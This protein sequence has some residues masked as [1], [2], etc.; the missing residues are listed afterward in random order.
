MKTL[1]A[2]IMCVI[3]CLPA[4]VMAQPD[5]VIEMSR[6]VKPEVTI[7]VQAFSPA[8]NTQDP[9]GIGEEGRSILENDL[10]I[11]RFFAVAPRASFR[12]LEAGEKSPS[13]V[14]YAE[15]LRLG[16]QWLIKAEYEI[17]PQNKAFTVVFRLYDAVNERFLYGKQYSGTMGLL[18]KVMHRFAD[19]VVAQLTGKRGVA[20]TRL[21][22]VSKESGKKEIY[23]VDFD[24]YNVERL[25][26]DNS[27]ALSPAWSPNGKNIVFTSYADR[28]PDLVIVDASGKNRKPVLRLYGLNAAPSWSPDGSRIALVLSKDQNSEIYTI[29]KKI[30]LTRL[31][32]HFNIDTSPSWSPDGKLIVFASDRSGTGAPQIFIMDAQAGDDGKVERISFESSY[33]D[34][35][36]WSPDGDKIA[37]SARVGKGFRIKIYDLNTKKTEDFTVDSGSQEGPAWSPDGRYIA[38]SQTENGNPQIYIKKIGGDKARQLTFLVGGGSGPAWSPYPSQ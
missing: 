34:N 22:F 12:E 9:R 29:D 3:T 26:K 30:K 18:R 36:A 2:L 17:N 19:E 5:V 27:V 28:N 11:S 23:A 4:G 25:T 38:Y 33:N 35:P 10:A 7:A 6:Q 32:R 1:M 24:G 14:G 15:W 16:V 37:Y 21:A 31:T 8:E 13:S 20:E